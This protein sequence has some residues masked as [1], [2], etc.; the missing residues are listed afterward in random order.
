MGGILSSSNSSKQKQKDANR[1]KAAASVS[2]IDRAMLDLKNSRDRLSRYKARLE[3]DEEKLISRAKAAKA[4]G[5]TKS[6][7]QLLKVK[8][9][10][11]NEVDSVENQLLTV[12]QMVQTIDSK[13]NEAAVLEAMRTGKDALQKM[14]EQTTVDDVLELM[15]QIQEQADVEKEVSTLLGQGHESAFSLE[16]EAAIEA[17]LLALD[18]GDAAVA[19]PEVPTDEPQS[20]PVAPDTKLPDAT[21]IT[22]QEETGRVALA[23]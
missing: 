7:L 4:A 10:K 18:G 5:K 6:A 14:H 22:S 12:L 9:M 19:M 11:R 23:S 21:T 17:E 2:Q 13:Q 16:D 20:L 8:K 1:A 3:K 15:D